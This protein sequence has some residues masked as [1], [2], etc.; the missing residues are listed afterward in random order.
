M[1]TR[2]FCR[3]LAELGLLGR[4]AQENYNNLIH[5][6]EVEEVLQGEQFFEHFPASSDEL[7][8]L[9]AEFEA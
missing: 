4:Y 6:D 7:D 9:E 8:A 1:S 5:K 3:L 2:V